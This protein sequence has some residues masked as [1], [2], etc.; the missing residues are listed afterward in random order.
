MSY[1]SWKPEH[2]NESV[3]S[4][5][6]Q[7]VNFDSEDLERYEPG[8]FHPVHLGDYYDDT[9]YKIVHKA[10]AMEVRFINLA[11]CSFY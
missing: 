1:S 2:D 4:A 9:R 11:G 7:C 5:R 10:F 6:F 3:Y 8:G